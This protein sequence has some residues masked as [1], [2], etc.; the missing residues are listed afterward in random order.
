[1]PGGRKSQGGQRRQQQKSNPFSTPDYHE[2]G[3][4]AIRT[5]ALDA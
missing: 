5:S 2:G 4:Q 3:I 1:V